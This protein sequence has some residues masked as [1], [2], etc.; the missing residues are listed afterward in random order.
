MHGSAIM[1]NTVIDLSVT[2]ISNPQKCKKYFETT[3]R[4]F[5]ISY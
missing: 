2:D 4:N 5:K 1:L 3:M